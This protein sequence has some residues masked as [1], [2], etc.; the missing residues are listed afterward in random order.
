MNKF[1]NSTSKTVV[2]LLVAV[3]KFLQHSGTGCP[4]MTPTMRVREGKMVQDK[5]IFIKGLEERE[6]A[7]R[8]GNLKHVRA[9]PFR[10]VAVSQI[11]T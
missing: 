8:T 6:E 10:E 1:A 11:T 7:D 2:G 5:P 3:V 9:G 4:V